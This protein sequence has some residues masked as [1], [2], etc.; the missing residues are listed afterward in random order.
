MNLTPEQ[1]AELLAGIARSQ[2]AIIDAIDRANPGFRSTYLLPTLNVAAN[3]RIPEVRLLDLPSRIL[4]RSQG[5]VGMDLET[6]LN[7]LNAALGQPAAAPASA[8][9]PK[10]AP[11][12]AAPAISADPE[13][14]F[15][16]S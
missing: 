12:S 4:L 11:P 14:E 15:F 9:A 13:N 8:T 10:A 5:R 2:Q 16:N 7:N 3:L 6:V 1:L